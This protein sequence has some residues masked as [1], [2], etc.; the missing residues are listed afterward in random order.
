MIGTP[1]LILEFIDCVNIVCLFLNYDKILQRMIGDD[2]NDDDSN[3]D[4]LNDDLTAPAERR[5]GPAHRLCHGEEET[6][7]D[8]PGGGD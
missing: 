7:Q 5:H 2:L 1:F 4:E 6:D 3:D 8:S